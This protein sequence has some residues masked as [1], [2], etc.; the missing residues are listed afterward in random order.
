MNKLSIVINDQAK[1]IQVKEYKGQRV[2]TLAEIDELHKRSSGTAKRNFTSNKR[3][4][5]EGEDYFIVT[6]IQK[7]EIRTLEIPNRGLTLITESGYLM[8][9]K[10]FQDELAWSVQRQLVKYYFKAK[11][12]IFDTSQLSPELQMFDGLF[13]A[14][15]KTE[16]ATHQLSEEIKATNDK[17]D[18]VSNILALNPTEWRKKIN[19]IINKIAN[20]RG[21]FEAYQD[22]RNES[23]QLLED[24]AKCQLSVRLINKRRKMAL[25]GAAKSR[26][27][28]TNKM[29]V[30]A[31]DARLTEIY[32]AVVKELAIKN[33]VEVEAS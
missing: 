3:H 18:N 1:E 7:D 29:D 13:K 5:V 23:Y 28:K 4:F 17:V 2:V 9:V 12:K 20:F 10:S 6:P 21:G 14:I 30:I 25:E 24:R 22:V 31:D 26:I 15:A 16:L 19:A 11:E 27:D 32:I 8:L 33:D